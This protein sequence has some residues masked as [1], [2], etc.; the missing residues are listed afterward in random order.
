MGLGLLLIDR[1][2]SEAVTSLERAVSLARKQ[3]DLH[4]EGW[5][6][7]NLGI[8]RSDL[9]ELDGARE[10]FLR[11]REIFAGGRAWD[12]ARAEGQLGNLARRRG[13]FRQAE[14]HYRRFRE[15][16]QGMPPETPSLL[17]HRINRWMLAMER[18]VGEGV[19][20][21]V[22]GAEG[23]FPPTYP[24]A[25]MAYQWQRSMFEL[26]FG[27]AAE[28]R[29]RAEQTLALSER[30]RDLNFRAVALVLLG[31]MDGAGPEP[32]DGRRKLLEARK[33]AV[34]LGN[35]ELEAEAEL[36]LAELLDAH[37]TLGGSPAAH[38]A[39]AREVYER[40]GMRPMLERVGTLTDRLARGT[41]EAGAGPEARRAKE[42]KT[43]YRVSEAVRSHEHLE[44]LLEKLLD[45]ALELMGAERGLIFLAAEGSKRLEARATRGGD[46]DTLRDAGQI[47]RHILR[48]SLDEARPIFSTNAMLDERYR[49]NRSV[50]NYGIRSFICAPLLVTDRVLGTIY[51]DHRKLEDLFQETDADFMMAFAG[52]AASA[53]DNAL[54]H[55]RLRNQVE[56][57]R[58]EVRERWQPVSFV[59][60]SAAMRQ[61]MDLVKR[62]G[63][64]EMN[65]LVRGE[66]G[67]GKELVARMLHDLSPRAEGPFVAVNCA[68]LP[69]SLVESELFGVVRGAATDVTERPGKFEEAGGGTLF[70]DEIGDLA[71]TA[72]AKIL[73]AIQ[74]RRIERLGSNRPVDLDLRLVAATH[75][76][77]EAAIEAGTFRSDLY[78]RLNVVQIYLPPL[79]DRRD[80]IL[81][82]LRHYVALFCREQKK[83][84]L[85]IQEA[86]LESYMAYEWPGN[87]RELRNAVER[88][89]LLAEEDRLPPFELPPTASA[90]PTDLSEAFAR[91]MGEREVKQLYARYVF[92]RLNRAKKRACEFLG[93]DFKTLMSRLPEDD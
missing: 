14:E 85:E 17:M 46:R 84:D 15:L 47:S 39:R 32:E 41:E 6:E 60:G 71:L 11:A 75:T 76:D 88:A 53:I 58:R 31:E 42:L 72:Q 22:R 49:G 3:V 74:E 10:H 33:C 38:L 66:S 55:G 80:D 79:R 43:L 62:A 48:Q 5:S 7:Y 89:V 23:E 25:L 27:D 24:R 83:P 36:L 30:Y 21:E 90:G 13:D 9:G 57:L 67:T 87:V 19:L 50:V 52:F 73:R 2:P 44:D 65:V 18:G 51:V 26:R 68:G 92:S 1:R 40:A 16:S 86:T 64:Q 34:D 93:I 37:P 91:G 12:V 61:V 54:L 78:F 28:A 8:A 69:D 4:I 29:C 70:L 82:L 20:E 63:P 35:L 59:H 81:E 56:H 45:A 77:L